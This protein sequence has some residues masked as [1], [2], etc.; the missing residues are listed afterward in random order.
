MN[1]AVSPRLTTRSK[2]WRRILQTVLVEAYC[3]PRVPDSVA[4]QARADRAGG[5]LSK[6]YLRR[7]CSPSFSCTACPT[8]LPV[9]GKTTKYLLAAK[10]G[11]LTG[12]RILSVNG[13]AMET[14]ADFSKTVKAG[15]GSPV[16]LDID[17]QQNGQI[18][19]KHDRDQADSARSKDHLRH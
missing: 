19:T 8:L 11:L 3:S 15:D 6:H 10:A 5:P 13:Q 17:R 2:R 14:W 4:R 1:C 7:C 16:K 9:I 12:D 18:H